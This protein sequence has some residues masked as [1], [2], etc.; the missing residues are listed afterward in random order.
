LAVERAGG[1]ARALQCDVSQIDDVLEL[2]REARS[3]FGSP[4]LLINNAGVAVG[5]KTGEVPLDDWKWVFDINLWGV[6]H[7]CHVFVPGMRERGAGHII[8]IASMA[9]LISTAEL[10]PYSVTKAGVVALSETLAAELR[11]L[12]VGV[13]VVCPAF[14]QTNIM[15]K[16]RGPVDSEMR[17]VGE[18]LMR[19]A[20]LRPR[21]VA[22]H[23]LARAEAGALYALPMPEG[24]LMWRVKRLVPERF[25]WVL[26]TAARSTLVRRT[27][28]R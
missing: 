10:G 28:M 19:R 7:G 24:R 23:A 5:G 25:G 15:E 22:R 18:E 3:W 13:T 12:D 21:D 27:L 4:N 11:G 1:R 9:G 20:R 26:A 6:V 8:N 2:E 14:F 17:K 16:S